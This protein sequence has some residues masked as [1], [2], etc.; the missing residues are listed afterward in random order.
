MGSS[1]GSH[2]LANAPPAMRMSVFVIYMYVHVG[3]WGTLNEPKWLCCI[4]V[5][6]VTIAAPCMHMQQLRCMYDYYFAFIDGSE[7]SILL[8]LRMVHKS[9]AVEDSLAY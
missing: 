2:S 3:L 4:P 7:N 9:N 1:V 6:I 8:V 5:V